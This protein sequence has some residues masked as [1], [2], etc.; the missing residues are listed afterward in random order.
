MRLD[1]LVADLARQLDD[2]A[3][4]LHG[5]GGRV[6][7]QD[8]GRDPER[9]EEHA[10]VAQLERQV[11]G[12]QQ[13]LEAHA[14]EARQHVHVAEVDQA[15]DEQAPVA[16]LARQLH[17]L[18]GALQQR[19]P[20]RR[21]LV[22]ARQEPQVDELGRDLGAQALLGVAPGRARAAGRA[23]QAVEGRPRRLGG[24]QRLGQRVEALGGARRLQAPAR[25]LEP[26]LAQQVVVGQVLGHLAPRA[27]QRLQLLGHARVQLAAALEEQALVGGVAGELVLEAVIREARAPRLAQ[28]PLH[29][30][31]AELR[32][33]V[34]R[35]L[36][37][38]RAHHG[39]QQAGGEL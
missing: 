15:G 25:G 30:E 17:R 7:E 22:L 27:E 2:G 5:G 14:R 36:L 23:P 20:Q 1:G 31:A 35:L 6:V 4:L 29:R 28:Q 33:D 9:V 18:G 8:L 16:E 38:G 24:L 37:A 13:P 3:E 32:L 39:A 11:V 26:A 12:L 10:V 19:R 34:G 21:V